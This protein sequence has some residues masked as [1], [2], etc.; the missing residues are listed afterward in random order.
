MERSCVSAFRLF[1]IDHSSL[2]FSV[3]SSLL[4]AS[5][6]RSFRLPFVM[7][8][9]QSQLKANAPKVLLVDDHEQNLELLDAYL[10]EL[11]VSTSTAKENTTLSVGAI[12]KPAG[13]EKIGR[14]APRVAT[15]AVGGMMPWMSPA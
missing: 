2:P 3:F 10:E 7:V 11:N 5:A 4:R 8:I 14:S 12:E 13:Q 1:C 15:S 9:S 6:F